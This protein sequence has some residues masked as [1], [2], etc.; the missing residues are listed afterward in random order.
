[1]THG[2]GESKVKVVVKH[3]LSTFLGDSLNV[4]IKSQLARVG[5]VVHPCR[6]KSFRKA[7]SSVMDDFGTDSVIID[8]SNLIVKLGNLKCEHDCFLGV[9][10]GVILVDR[11]S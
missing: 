7:M 8:N 9:I 6:V 11:F 3:P 2:L 1:V 10:E 4:G 5:R